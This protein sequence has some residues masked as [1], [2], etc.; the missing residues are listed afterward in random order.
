M[1]PLLG[2]LGGLVAAFVTAHYEGAKERARQI[3]ALVRF[4]EAIA[5]CI[6]E[7]ERSLA[8]NKVPTKAGNRLKLILERFGV[9]LD[10]APLDKD[11][12]SEMKVLRSQIERCLID[13]RFLDEAIRGH[14]LRVPEAKREQLLHAMARTAAGVE[15]QAVVLKA[16]IG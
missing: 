15:G 9:A 13:G 14:I 12:K 7:M 2:L 10:K 11:T 1:E 5:T 3:G 4:L 16:F 8:R 6:S